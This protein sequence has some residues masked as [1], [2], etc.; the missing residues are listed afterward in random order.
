[1][2]DPIVLPFPYSMP[3]GDVVI[4]SALIEAFRDLKRNPWLLDF[5]FSYFAADLLTAKEYGQKE[6]DRYKEWFL[7]NKVTIAAGTNVN[8]I[9][10]PHVVIWPGAQSEAEAIT[11]DINETADITIPWPTPPVPVAAFTPLSYDSVTGTIGVPADIDLTRIF[12]GDNVYDRNANKNYAILDIGD[13]TIVILPG[14]TP[15]L[16]QA[17]ILRPQA[18]NMIVKLESITTQ[19]NY[20]IDVIVPGDA[21]LCLVLHSLVLFCLYRY[22]EWFLEGRGYERSQY[23]STG[24]QGLKSGP[25]AAQLMWQR[26]INIVGYVRTFWPKHIGPPI[27]GLIPGTSS[28]TGFTVAGG[29]ESDPVA[30][31]SA[32]PRLWTSIEDVGEE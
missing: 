20:T 3:A 28:Q 31:D 26:S 12:V 23:S 5:A 29:A 2:S 13:Q 18:G 22:K 11:G 15:N 17:Q 8:A 25:N 30:L 24:L 9:E 7:G 32:G 10:V 1:M 14:S 21:A 19:D 16:T 4:R 27:A 6:I